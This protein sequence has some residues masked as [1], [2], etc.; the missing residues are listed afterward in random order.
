M[1]LDHPEQSKPTPPPGGEWKV[2]TR[3]GPIVCNAECRN[4]P[5]GRRLGECD[6]TCMGRNVL[7]RLFSVGMNENVGVDRNQSAASIRS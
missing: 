7:G 1:R 5:A 6:D 3:K 4:R 2:W